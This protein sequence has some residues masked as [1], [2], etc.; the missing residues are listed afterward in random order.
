MEPLIAENKDC[1]IQDGNSL[2]H[3]PSRYLLER[4]RHGILS[5]L[6]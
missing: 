1:A 2:Q 6:Y 4:A 5:I 3:V